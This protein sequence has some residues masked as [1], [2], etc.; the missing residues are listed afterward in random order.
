VFRLVAGTGAFMSAARRP[1][2]LI[3]YKF[4]PYAGVGGFRWAKL[5]KYL[6]RLGHEIHVVTVPWPAYGPNTLT[7]DAVEPGVTVH[8]IPSGSPHR[9]RHRPLSGRWRIAA[10]HYALR[11]LDAVLFYDDEAQRW[12]RHLVGFCERLIDERGIEVAVATGHPFQA[13]RWAAQLKRRRPGLKLVQDFRDPWADNPFR[14]LSRR[15]AQHVRAWQREAVEAA[16]AVVSVTPP[17]LDLFLQGTRDKLAAV[18]T[19]GVDPEE[20]SANGLSPSSADG[21]TRLT[22]IGSITNGRSRPLDTLLGAVREARRAGERIQ[23]RLVGPM[24]ESVGR[25]NGDLV[26]DGL[27]VLWPTMSQ[28]DALGLVAE[29]EYALQLNAR[30]FPYAASTKIYEYALLRVPQVSLNYGG[31]VDEVVRDHGFGYSVDLSTRPDLAGF[32]RSLPERACADRDGRFAFDV[33]PFTYPVLAGR[34]ASLIEDL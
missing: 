20:S 25:A 33:E 31:F 24:L 29:G 13:N 15:R 22:H 2:L 27:L 1:I 12:G 18:I 26:E 16:D 11:A 3:A 8:R 34:Y 21:V 10:R 5:S 30:E 14:S 19:N 9:F 32:V 4:P 28:S 7:A 6:A 23:V 17:L